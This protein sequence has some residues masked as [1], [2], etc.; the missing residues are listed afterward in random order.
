MTERSIT[1]R[2]VR[3]SESRLRRLEGKARN[4]NGRVALSV[5]TW[6]GLAGMGF[7]I[8]VAVAGLLIFV[9][10]TKTETAEA[11]TLHQTSG[12]PDI[13]KDISEA[14]KKAAAAVHNTIQIGV[15][16]GAS[17]LRTGEE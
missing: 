16:V 11:A 2:E 4:G 13:R 1:E 7:T 10:T 8:I 17:N 3:I 12:H 5:G 9:F 15:K 6:L 14:R